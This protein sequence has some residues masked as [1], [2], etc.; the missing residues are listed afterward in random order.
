MES[1]EKF[2]W[3]FFIG[4]SFILTR[5]S[6]FSLFLDELS[7]NCFFLKARFTFSRKEKVHFFRNFYSEYGVRVFFSVGTCC[8]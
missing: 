5:Y 4:K 8:L 7:S 6:S 2:S 3:R 1:E